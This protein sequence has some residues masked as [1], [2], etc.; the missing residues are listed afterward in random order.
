M[1]KVLLFLFFLTVLPGVAKA[2][3]CS[4]N[5]CVQFIPTNT[6]SGTKITATAIT[7][8]AGNTVVLIGAALGSGT[9]GTATVS[10]GGQTW[11]PCSGTGTGAFTMIQINT[12]T[13]LGFCFYILNALAVSTAAV[14]TPSNCSCSFLGASSTEYSA[15]AANVWDQFGSNSLKTTTAGTQNLNCTAANVTPAVSNEVAFCAGLPNSGPCANTGTGTLRDGASTGFCT[16]DQT[17]SAAFTAKITDSA[18]SGDT[19]G[20]MIILFK[21]SGG[22]ASQFSQISV[23]PGNP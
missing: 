1:R 23:I 22:A 2:T 12:T 20:A 8:T 19:Y 13:V 9:S 10:G 3:S 6:T 17:V 5:G 7:P 15:S 11:H 18:G 4:G 16:M 21:P 14:V